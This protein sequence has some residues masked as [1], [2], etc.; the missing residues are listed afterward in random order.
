MADETTSGKAAFE[1]LGRIGVDLASL[2]ES[3][4]TSEAHAKDHA[5]KLNRIFAEVKGPDPAPPAGGGSASSDPIA[6]AAARAGSGEQAKIVAAARAADEAR[7]QERA[8]KAAAKAASRAGQ[9][10]SGAPD[11]P[12]DEGGGGGGEGGGAGGGAGGDAGGR[13]KSTATTFA[14]LAQIARNVLVPALAAISPELARFVSIGAASARTAT[15]FGAAIGGIAVA[16]AVASTAIAKFVQAANAMTAASI[17]AARAVETL[18][19]SRS[20]ASM[21]KAT[22]DLAK[23]NMYVQQVG[24][25]NFTGFQQVIARVNYTLDAITGKSKA[26]VAALT[27]EAT[28]QANILLPIIELPKKRAEAMKVEAQAD[29]TAATRAVQNATSLLMLGAAH[30]KVA[31]ASKKKYDAERED[32]RIA[33]LAA[34]ETGQSVIKAAVVQGAT[35]EQRAA[36]AAAFVQKMLKFDIDAK[37]IDVRHT[38]ENESNADAR[39]KSYSKETV[40]AEGFTQEE[41]Q[42]NQR[43]IENTASTAQAVADANHIIEQIRNDSAGSVESRAKLDERLEASRKNTLGPLLAAVKTE[44][45]LYESQK[46]VLAEQIASGTAGASALEKLTALE[47]QHAEVVIE[48]QNRITKARAE[49]DAKDAQARRAQEQ[50][51]VARESR[52]LAHAVATGRV[53]TQGQIQELTRASTDPR[54]NAD[55]QQQAEQQ[56]FALRRQYANDYFRYYRNLGEDN[57]AQQLE[58]AKHLRDENVSGSAAWFAAS[59][60]VYDVY[61]AIYEQAKQIASQTVGIAAS[62]VEREAQ[63]KE[64]KKRPQTGPKPPEMTLQDVD[65]YVL[66]A[67]ERD[68]AIYAG[69]S[70][71]PGDVTAAVGRKGMWQE[72]DR[73]GMTFADAF[74]KMQQT[75]EQR[76]MAE[77]GMT[78][79]TATNTFAAAVDRF[80]DILPGGAGG[81][82]GGN[83]PGAVFESA[84]PGLR[85]EDFGG[86]EA[87]RAGHAANLARIRADVQDNMGAAFASVADG[88]RSMTPP[89]MFGTDTETQ[90]GG[91]AGPGGQGVRDSLRNVTAGN[92]YSNISTE[93]EGMSGSVVKT[94]GSFESASE[95]VRS[96]VSAVMDSASALR[97]SGGRGGGPYQGS[98]YILPTNTIGNKDL[99]SDSSLAA[100]RQLQQERAR[101]PFVQDTAQ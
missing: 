88:S 29:A 61:K 92:K 33:K 9:L 31:A 32:L 25:D 64:K 24:N 68:E 87:R 44:D 5:A 34:S 63:E 69:G 90:R 30:D 66:R 94:K 100:G 26:T 101:T 50:A 14:R 18:D 21:T 43:R 36:L 46:R 49:A 47:K 10:P 75:P 95:A 17:E 45:A 19:F 96:F 27:E 12:S 65:R 80:A 82:P 28:N 13:A 35:L 1:V 57:F 4:K 38:A 71:R 93:F 3:L 15:F 59:Q 76:M 6:R 78:F 97:Q 51:E 2:D 73:T 74:S 72:M 83:V 40:A 56:V 37:N 7:A 41:I 23:Y 58:S 11:G 62:E 89:G 8:A 55:Q 70:A 20:S 81:G 39:I 16:A 52:L 98:P 54:R 79:S 60:K 77:S 91:E 22:E 67:R 84:V 53:S 99:S 48:S 42:R 86:A 85:G